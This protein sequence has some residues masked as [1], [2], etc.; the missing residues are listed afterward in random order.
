VI[1]Y[2][3]DARSDVF[4]QSTAALSM[5]PSGNTPLCRLMTQGSHLGRCNEPSPLPEY[6]QTHRDLNLLYALPE[7]KSHDG[8]GAL[9][10]SGVPSNAFS[11]RMPS[12]PHR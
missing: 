5:A 1:S 11:P 2:S 6:L 10:L 7:P 12:G 4:Y 3:T 9:G 8:L